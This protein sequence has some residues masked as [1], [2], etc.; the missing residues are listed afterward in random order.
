MRR[1]SLSKAKLLVTAESAGKGTRIYTQSVYDFRMEKEWTREQI[2]E[3]GIEWFLDL[4]DMKQALNW[5]LNGDERKYQFKW[6]QCVP[7]RCTCVAYIF[8]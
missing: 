5:N 7:G 8:D 1:K 4:A 6:G 2:K 3:R